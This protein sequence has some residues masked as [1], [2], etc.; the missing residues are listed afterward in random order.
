[1]PAPGGFVTCRVERVGP[2]EDGN[3]N[4]WLTDQGGKFSHWF[5]AMA[6]MKRE[7][8]STALT[9]ISTGLPVDAA[10]S[11]TDEYSQLNR[12]YVRR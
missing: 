7:I 4:V 2:S 6:A 11:S 9:A 5:V 12:I 3:I 1:M 8:L 10:V